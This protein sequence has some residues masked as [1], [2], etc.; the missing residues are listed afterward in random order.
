[1]LVQPEQSRDSRT[2][3]DFPS[4]KQATSGLTQIFE[5]ILRQCNPG[6]QELS[7][8]MADLHRYIESV[9]DLSMLVFDPKTAQYRPLTKQMIKGLLQDLVKDTRR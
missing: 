7:Y 3:Y 4:L 8:T 2:F 6:K 1:M 9:P 5:N